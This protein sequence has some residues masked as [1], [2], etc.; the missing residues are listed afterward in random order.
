M[1]VKPFYYY[2][3][4]EMFVFGTEIKAIN[5]LTELKLEINYL[6]ARLYLIPNTDETTLTFYEKILRLPAANY[7]L[8]S[9]TN[10][11][12][13]QYWK[14]NRDLKIEMENEEQYLTKFNEIFNKS[15]QCRLRS[16]YPLGFELS[17]GLDSS[18]IVVTAKKYLKKRKLKTF[19]LISKDFEDN[20]EKSYIETVIKSGGIDPCFLLVDSISPLNNSE[21]ISW[22]LEQPLHSPNVSLFW[23]LYKK[24][25]EQ[26]IRVLFRGYDGDGV[27]SQGQFYFKEL[28]LRLKWKKLSKEIKGYSIRFNKNPYKIFLTHCIFP[29]LPTFFRSFVKKIVIRKKEGDIIVKNKNLKDIT[30]FEEKYK[31]LDR[32]NVNPDTAKEFH[33]ILINIGGHQFAFE[34]LDK[35]SS[36]FQMESRY[37]FFDKRVVEYCYAIPTSQKFKLGM[38]RIL[39]REGIPELPEQIKKRPY[40]IFMSPI[41]EKNLLKF[42]KKELNNLLANEETIYNQFANPKRLKKIYEDYK[43]NNYKSTDVNELW[44]V[45]TLILWLKNNEN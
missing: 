38:D 7:M 37:P 9:K 28:F 15:I 1:G 42:E 24:M 2:V 45:L 41:F 22:Y 35:I 18:S 33:Y 25:E 36:A 30:K 32:S 26:D 16:D 5:L 20:N 13:T 43:K 44:K 19:S 27:L 12:K 21:E 4:E 3:D 14:L 10:F 17:G 34:Y 40:K 8:I 6:M 39:L 29:S 31:E 23:N 11:I